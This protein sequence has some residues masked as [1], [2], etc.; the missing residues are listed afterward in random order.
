MVGRK[1]KHY[2]GQG[3]P[4]DLA[5][6]RRLYGL[7]AA[8][9]D[10]DA[11]AMLGRMYCLGQGGPPDFAEARRLLGLAAAQGDADAQAM[12]GGMHLIDRAGGPQ[13]FA[14]ARRLL[15]L[16]AAQ[17]HAEAQA[18]LGRMYCLGQGGPKDLAEARRLLG[19][20]AAQGDAE[21][22]AMLGHV[23]CLN[24]GGLKDLAEARR[25]LGLAAAQGHANAQADLGSMHL[26]AG[27]GGPKDLAEAR[28]LLGL[29]AAQGHAEAQARL[30]CMHLIGQ[31]GQQDIAA[32][33]ARRLLGLAAAQGHAEARADLGTVYCLGIGGPED[34]AE[35]RR[36]YGLAA[37]Q[38]HAKALALLGRMYCLGQ[39][40]PKDDLEARRLYGL[41]AAQGNEGA[42]VFLD[43]LDRAAEAQRAKKQ[44]GA[45]AMMAQ[46]LAEDAK[47]KKANG[48]A[49]STKS[50]K[51]K[52]SCA[53]AAPPSAAAPAAP[54]TPPSSSATGAESAAASDAALRDATTAGELEG[55]STALEVH[56]LLA[57][58][59]VLREA[60]SLRDRLKERRKQKSQ[61]QRRLHAGAMEAL[62][63][64]QGCAAEADVLRAGI[65]VAEAHAGELPALD[66]ALAAACVRLEGLSMDPLSEHG[67]A[68]AAA[69]ASEAAPLAGSA[70]AS[71][72]FELDELQQVTA[73][74]DKG[75]LIGR[76][77]FGQVFLGE[78]PA[79]LAA[80][81]WL[82]RVAVKRADLSKLE[83]SDLHREVAILR[84]CSHPHLLPLLGYC[85]G[86]SAACL[87]FPLMV[88]GSLQT[89]LDLAQSDCEYLL[90]MEHF[91][92]VPKPLTWRQKLRVLVQAVDAL[93]YLHT[94]TEDKG[95]T[96]HRDFKCA[97][98]QDTRL[99]ARL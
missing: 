82:Q 67:A 93:L 59:D 33:E 65:A 53:S 17:G 92:A 15:G 46:L 24:Q 43:D 68:L 8:Q 38:G 99:Q 56:R 7:A 74:F 63:Q 83:L 60:R 91:T 32:A 11:Q 9:G 29:A 51:G 84:R 45:D 70:E 40:G 12:L 42:R 75:R 62:L 58:E 55:L 66:T 20:A 3:G 30:G 28:R 50:A 57:S 54:V 96:W 10:A 87:V 47:E 78:A 48:A 21:A 89:R 37:A 64:L 22:Q 80:C 31:G 2:E 94:P 39:G 5:E 98:A 95:C 49:K 26:Q 86:A 1:T 69:P 14:E 36:L 61:R 13:D 4:Q 16:A 25:L 81:R 90:R 52:K 76:G 35:A 18:M 72:E 73:G 71:R 19:L 34:F 6:A 77:G 27:Q 41:A 88:G 44:A 97:P 23:Y 79:S 85:V